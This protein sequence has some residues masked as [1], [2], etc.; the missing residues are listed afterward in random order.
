MFLGKIQKVGICGVVISQT[1]LQELIGYRY[2]LDTVP[3]SSHKKVAEPGGLTNWSNIQQFWSYG[4]HLI[5]TWFFLLKFTI[6]MRFGGSLILRRNH[7]KGGSDCRVPVWMKK[8]QICHRCVSHV[9]AFPNQM[10]IHT[11]IMKIHTYISIYIYI[12]IYVF[13]YVIEYIYI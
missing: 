2:Q 6:S 1:N 5:Q 10:K 9:S 3:Y 12:H 7:R 13:V 4:M 11:Y 8:L